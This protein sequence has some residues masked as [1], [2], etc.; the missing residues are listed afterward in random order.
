M[1]TSP[2]KSN[3]KIGTFNIVKKVGIEIIKSGNFSIKSY[4]V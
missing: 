1:G 3:P 2:Y 4:V